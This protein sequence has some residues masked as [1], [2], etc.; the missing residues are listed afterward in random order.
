LRSCILFI[1][2][3]TLISIVSGAFGQGEVRQSI[4]AEGDWYKIEIGTD[5]IYK[6]DFQFL[7]DMGI[8]PGS[9]DPRNIQ[10]WSNPY[11]ML[12]QLNSASRPIDLNQIPI[13]INGEEDG[14]FNTNDFIL[15][16]GKGPDLVGFDAETQAAIYQKHRYSDHSYYFLTI[17]S[18]TGTRVASIPN[19]GDNFKIVNKF[20]KTQS[21]EVDEENRVNSGREWYERLSNSGTN[22]G[23]V[24]PGLAPENPV[25]VTS[26]VMA[27]SY[28]PV[29]FTISANGLSFGG[30][31]VKS[32]PEGRYTTKGSVDKENFS[33]I[34]TPDPVKKDSITLNYTFTKTGG[35][36]KGY[37]DYLTVT[38]T[39]ILSF[40]GGQTV[41]AYR[42]SQEPV[43]FEITD[44]DGSEFIWD[45]TDPV[46]VSNL[47]FTISNN[48]GYFGSLLPNQ[49]QFVIINPNLLQEYPTFI[50]K[51]ENQNIQGLEPANMVIIS[52][53]KF[54]PEAIRLANLRR[55]NDNLT[56][57]VV[58]PEMIFN[59]FSSGMQDVTAIRDY[60]KYL[61][62]IDHSMNGIRYVLMFG[63]GTFD[64][65]GPLEKSLNFVP[66]YESRNSL[67]PIYSHSSDDYFGL[68]EDQEGEW[69]ESFSGDETMEL[70]IGRL[71]VKSLD[72]ARIVVDKYYDYALNPKTFGDWRNTITF[73]ADDGDNNLHLRQA[74]K[75]SDTVVLKKPAINNRKIYID[76]F[77]QESLPA[78]Q[79]A[80]EV[81]ESITK[82]IQRGTLIINYTGHGNE[83]QWADERVL[84]WPMIDSWTN[85][86]R[87]PIFVTATCEFGRHDDPGIIS[88]GERAIL[89]PKGGAIALVTTARPVFA[90]QNFELNNSFY[91]SILASSKKDVRMGDVFKETKNNSLAGSVNRNFSL[92]GDPSFQVAFPSE[93]IQ[94]ESINDSFSYAGD[95]LAALS[96]VNIK[97]Y[98]S[99]EMDD[100]I[101]NFN[102]VINLRLYEKPTQIRTLGDENPTYLFEERDNILFKGSAYVTNGRFS[103]DF[104]IPKNISYQY[105]KGK[106]SMYAYSSELNT[107]AS[108]ANDNIIIGGSESNIVSDIVPPE[109]SLFIGDTTFS[110]GMVVKPNTLLVAKFFDDSGITISNSNLNQNIQAILDDTTIFDLNEYYSTDIGTYTSG[111]IY[112]PLNNLSTGPHTITVKA[113]DTQNNP[114]EAVISFV[115]SEKDQLVIENLINYPNPMFQTTT[116]RFEHNRAGEDLEIHLQIY[117]GS[118]AIVKESRYEMYQSFTIAD[119]IEWDG[120]SSTGEKIRAGIYYYRVVVRS[121]VDGASSQQYQKLIIY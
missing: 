23:F 29:E 25:F 103:I 119:G 36:T 96:T 76:A 95:T 57:Q 59:E 108:G 112:F 121:S 58:T 9:I 55:S 39:S 91:Q 47:E 100:I 87:L 80:S 77:K 83:R 13:Y 28:D 19:P 88:G 8:N 15:F 61:Y 120:L 50:G 113:W 56:V 101:G 3:I 33:A 16:Y 68:M 35:E 67:H 117:N 6:I 21:W 45:I 54:I 110:E 92:L 85:E 98:I 30:H 78:T 44:L 32:V 79:R 22:Y 20:V 81:N 89:K 17:G 27:F 48:N 64:Y 24:F 53:E 73:V 70:G 97:G 52:Y 105:G 43:T 111:W 38:A 71:P 116:F 18:S 99:N 42:E 5:N 75:L 34:I 66:I 93:N 1:V 31:S 26:Q 109:I 86:F 14:V 94:I 60:I 51:I 46:N 90:S 69:I 84:D 11:G 74:N 104:I 7:S 102:G 2:I 106:I 115:V 40:Y 62:D 10:I 4:L 37:L 65:K 12:P 49:K 63:K 72:E 114:A 82:S 41:F 107:D 118:G